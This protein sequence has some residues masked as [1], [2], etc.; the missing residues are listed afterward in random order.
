MQPDDLKNSLL[1]KLISIEDN[2][3]L[4]KVNDLIGNVNI[5]TSIFKVTAN[6][7]DMLIKSEEDI[8]DGNFI[9]N[10]ELNDEEDNWLNE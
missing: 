7:K 6:Q 9:S 3:L 8:Y 5:N 1:D 4:E 2:S 10:E